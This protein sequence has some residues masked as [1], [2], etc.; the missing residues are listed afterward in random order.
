MFSY[1]LSKWSPYAIF[2]ATIMAG[3]LAYAAPATNGTDSL[4]M[5]QFGAAQLGTSE[6]ATIRGGFDLSSSLSINFTFQQID[7]QGTNIIQS[8]IVPMTTLTQTAP[9]AASVIISQNGTATGTSSSN[10]TVVTPGNA[11]SITVSST[12]NNG[13]SVVISQLGGS[14]ITNIIT[15]QANNTL[16]SQVT[17]MNIDI[18]GMS[19]WLSQQRNDLA[20]SGGAFVSSSFFH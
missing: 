3:P 5:L 13:Q 11:S 19:Q 8:I 1:L 16:L 7:Y 18:S 14:G 20:S 10:D 12:A 4:N 15:N 2:A 17:N 9:S 6:L